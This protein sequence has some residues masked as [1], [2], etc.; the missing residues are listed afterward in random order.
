M[1]I[2][3]RIFFEKVFVVFSPLVISPFWVTLVRGVSDAR[4]WCEWRLCVVWVMLVHGVRWGLASF[5]CGYRVV[6][7]LFVA[8]TIVSPLNSLDTFIV[9]QY[10]Q[11]FFIHT[12]TKVT[13]NRVITQQ[14]VIL[15]LMFQIFFLNFL[16]L[17]WKY[18]ILRE[19]CRLHKHA[20]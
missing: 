16:K 12:I 6:P 5:A 7:A 15:A 3:P 2:Y 17:L 8:E 4:V 9:V 13:E 19:K 10:F 18:S 11:W 1:T 20:A 14:R